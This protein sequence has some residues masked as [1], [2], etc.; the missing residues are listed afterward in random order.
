MHVTVRFGLP[1]GTALQRR[2]RTFP[3]PPL[4]QTT[5]TAILTYCLPGGQVEI[6]VENAARKSLFP[7][8]T[9][10]T[11]HFLGRPVVLCVC[12]CV[13]RAKNSLKKKIRQAIL[14]LFVG[15]P[16]QK[17]GVQMQILK[18]L[19]VHLNPSC[20]LSLCHSTC[21]G[22]FQKMSGFDRGKS[23]FTTYNFFFPHFLLRHTRRG[24]KKED[25]SVLFLSFFVIQPVWLAPCF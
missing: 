6:R 23:F 11:H 9:P 22:N 14:F 8:R 5:T 21:Q 19:K 13:H 7:R 10:L 17:R 1:Y 2:I 18:I 12:V 25:L 16:S 20:C 3:H 24:E 15:T 4:A